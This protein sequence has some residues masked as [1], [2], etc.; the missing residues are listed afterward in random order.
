M[1]NQRACVEIVHTS[2]LSWIK[3]HV[4]AADGDGDDNDDE[5]VKSNQQSIVDC[6]T[7]S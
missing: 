6:V 2:R 4:A 1:L 3:S 7:Y 5:K